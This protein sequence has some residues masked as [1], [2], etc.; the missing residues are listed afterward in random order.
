MRRD[1]MRQLLLE[2]LFGGILLFLAV[3][4]TL[5]VAVKFIDSHLKLLPKRI[6]VKRWV[7]PRQVLLRSISMMA[8]IILAFIA[9]H[10]LIDPL[11]PGHGVIHVYAPH[12]FPTVRE[13]LRV[14]MAPVKWDGSV[15]WTRKTYGPFDGNGMVTRVLNFHIFENRVYLNVYDESMPAPP[16]AVKIVRVSGYVRQRLW[17]K[18]ILF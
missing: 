2:Y 10:L 11:I 15:D 8:R 6:L 12:K 13:N 18:D 14:E 3:R 1:N 5:S 4:S 17:D 9:G 7:I 16:V